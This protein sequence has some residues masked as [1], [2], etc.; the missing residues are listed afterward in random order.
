MW[1]P[2]TRRQHSRAGLRYETDLIDAEWAVIKPLMPRPEPRGRPPV[3]TTREILNAMVSRSARRY[4]MAADPQGS[5]AA[6]DH[7]RLLQPLARHRAVRP[8]QPPPRHG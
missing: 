2:T 4:R 3:W 1:T 7:V 6:F 8:D 5:T